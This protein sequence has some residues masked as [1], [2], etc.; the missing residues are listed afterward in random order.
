MTVH[1]LN[2]D[3]ADG[4]SKKIGG[5]GKFNVLS[6][7]AQSP[8]FKPIYETLEGRDGEVDMGGNFEG[9]VLR[10]EIK[11]NSS[12]IMA[13]YALRDEIYRLFHTREM[14]VLTSSRQ[15]HKRWNVRV[16]SV[17]YVEPQ[18]GGR[19]GS[20]TLEFKS[21][22]HYAVGKLVTYTYSSSFFSLHNE[23]DV[24]I[25]PRE[26]YLSISFKGASKDL[27]IIRGRKSDVEPATS[28]RY[29][30]E[31]TENE[32]ITLEG[33]RYMKGSTSIL[34]DTNK[35]LITLARGMNSFSVLGTKGGFKVTISFRPCYL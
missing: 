30:G 25:D 31:T 32:T 3:Y 10:A 24:L 1:T 6:F 35:G 2:I 17:Y 22:R 5:D 12:D 4:T 18:G 34:K 23:G 26:A 8:V 29:T 11:F 19:Y 13:F 14:F 21:D 15:P 28:F 33:L 27:E 20:F 9:R 16:Q 7:A